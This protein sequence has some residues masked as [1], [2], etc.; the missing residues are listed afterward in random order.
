VSDCKA[1]F[2]PCHPDKPPLVRVEEPDGR[3]Y[4][5]ALIDLLMMHE[6]RIM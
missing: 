2:F 5:P 4:L 3:G 6:A 1:A